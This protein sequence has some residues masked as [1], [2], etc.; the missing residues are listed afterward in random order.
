MKID[1]SPETIHKMFNSVARRYDS[2]NNLMSFGTHKYV[3]YM[4]IKNLDIKP[5]DSVLDLCCGTGDLARLVKKFQPEA[6]VTGIDFSEKM[7]EIA[8]NKNSENNPL[9]QIKYIQGDVTN[10]P[11][12]DN[13]FD[14]VTMGFGLRNIANAEKA[15]EEAYR[16][17]RP[18]GSFLHLDFGK[19][20]FIS[21]IYD[22]TTPLLIRLASGNSISYSYLINSKKIFPL[23]EELIKDFEIKGFKFKK[24]EDYLLGVIS[25]QIMTK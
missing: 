9:K 21:K 16:V 3:K 1:K 13:S 22:K 19:K 8:I 15:V 12:E 20:N 25:V 23:P 11:Y 10:L 6:H 2:L 7:L 14:F 17:L 24:R 4:S 18:N 5:H